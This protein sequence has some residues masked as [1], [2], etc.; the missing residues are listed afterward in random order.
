[1]A[2]FQTHSGLLTASKTG[3][4][5][6]L[7]FPATPSTL[8]DAPPALIDALG[9][10]PIY[11]GKSR[12]DYLLEVASAAEV[13]E[14]A[15]DFAML[16]KLDVRGIMVTSRGDS[17]HPM[18]MTTISSHASSHPVPVSTKI[19]SPD[20]PIAAWRRI[21]RPGWA[22]R[23]SSP[24]RRRHVGACCAFNLAAI[25]FDLRDRP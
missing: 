24:I 10:E 11:V 4:W 17:A 2:R 21:G 23:H 9:L 18:V 22:R 16:R 12:F 1:M 3:D 25:A 8:A 7:D 13:R 20:R 6:E 15:P 19:R 5:I 14:L